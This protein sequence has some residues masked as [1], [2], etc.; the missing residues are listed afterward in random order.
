MCAHMHAARKVEHAGRVCKREMGDYGEVADEDGEM[1]RGRRGRSASSSGKKTECHDDSASGGRKRLRGSA[2]GVDLRVRESGGGGGGARAATPFATTPRPRATPRTPKSPHPVL[3]TTA[4]KAILETVKKKLTSSLGVEMETTPHDCCQCGS[5]A[6][7]SVEC[8]CLAACYCSSTCQK[9]NFDA[10]K[11]QCTTWLLEDG[12][13]GGAM[14]K[15]STLSDARVGV[16]VGGGSAE[17]GWTFE[18]P[19]TVSV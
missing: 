12:R 11:L 9:A 1:S 7:G 19:P 18:P 13:E 5:S 6:L 15:D 8:S 16:V 2:S 17:E 14:T 10:H 3:R 4:E